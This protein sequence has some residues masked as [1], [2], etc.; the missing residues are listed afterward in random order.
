MECVF[1]LTVFVIVAED[2]D[3]FLLAIE[4]Y[5]LLIRFLRKETLVV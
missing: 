5:H 3:V 1:T 4:S 2:L